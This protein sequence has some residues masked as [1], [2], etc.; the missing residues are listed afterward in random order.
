[1]RLTNLWQLS[2]IA[3][4]TL[5]LSLPSFSQKQDFKKD[6]SLSVCK[7]EI[8]TQFKTKTADRIQEDIDGDNSS[9]TDL[10]INTKFYESYRYN[11]NKILV[12]GKI[13]FGD[14]LTVYVNKIAHNLLKKSGN[15]E[16]IKKLNFYVIK[17]DIVNAL[18]MPDGTI[19]VTVG[20]LSQIEN[21]AQ[22]AFT[23]AHEI[24]HF[25]QKHGLNDYRD[26][27]DL[28]KEFRRSDMTYREA[29]KALSDFSK[30]NELE[31]DDKGYK[32]FTDAGYDSEEANKMLLV[33]QYSYLPFD[34]IKFDPTFFNSGK[35]QIPASYFSKD[36]LEET[37]ED[38]SDEDDTYSTHPNIETRVE[39]LKEKK[40]KTGEKRFFDVKEFDYINTKA[41]FENQYIHL[42]EKNFVRAVYESY[43]L[44]KQY[45]ENVYLD[46]CIAKGLYGISKVNTTSG[47]ATRYEDE[48]EEGNLSELY[49]MFNSRMED[50]ELNILALKALLNLK[51]SVYNPFVK[52][53]VFDLVKELDFD[54]DD[55]IF[56]LVEDTNSKEKKDPFKFLSDEEYEKLTK[57]EKIRYNEKKK[58]HLASSDTTLEKEDDEY[59]KLAFF[60]QSTD[61]SFKA[62]FDEVEED[63]DVRFFS[64]LDYAVQRKIRKERQKL[65]YK[66]KE[67]EIDSILIFTPY[68]EH[69]DKYDE[70]IVQKS[71]ESQETLSGTLEELSK[72][73][74]VS[75]KSLSLNNVAN[76]TVKEVNN[77]FILNEWEDEMN[78]SYEAEMV[79]MTQDRANK[80]FKEFGY[81]HIMISGVFSQRVSKGVIKP[82]FLPAV[83]LYT[84]PVFIPVAFFQSFQP[85]YIT[86][87]YV[88]VLD[89]NGYVIFNKRLSCDDK[90]NVKQDEVF[91]QDV[92]D[93]IVLKK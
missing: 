8:P 50:V 70:V 40:S 12:G 11:Q 39:S 48:I 88:K 86:V 77:L 6:Y 14:E 37:I 16:L 26:A 93:Q 41:R 71:L 89:K 67:K 10:K 52:D 80:V 42:I 20:L 61:E 36:K 49:T 1:M 72:Q 92:F 9:K 83:A 76:L 15:E 32:M 59:Y 53:L 51:D 35:Y 17:S 5:C 46:Q 25:T 62:I 69:Y 45:P 58:I 19:F 54:Y 34:E 87:K 63:D 65:T 84:A 18:C 44:K 74:K 7:G 55:F 43:L 28:T 82:L 66:F 31:S 29:M 79:S 81:K 47:S 85:S 56:E 22:L 57:V 21:E 13:L 4:S 60:D 78:E 91:F 64:D 90:P 23:L 3:F 68:Y 2:M 75:Y 30:E 73:S 38:N 27:L 24:T 33:L